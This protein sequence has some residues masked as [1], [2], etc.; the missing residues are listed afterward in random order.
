VHGIFFGRI[1]PSVRL[2]SQIQAPAVVI[3]H[4]HDLIHP[5][6]DAA[7][8]ADELPDA[9]FVEARSIL[10][11]RRE[12]E[13]I[14]AEVLRFLADVCARPKPRRRTARPSTGTMGT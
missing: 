5:A 14:D 1:A 2:R 10:E 9:R 12:P 4:P 6:A 11:W 8:L 7:M 13:R 3:G